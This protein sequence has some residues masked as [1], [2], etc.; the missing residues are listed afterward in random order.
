MLI[1]NK[2]DLEHQRVVSTQE[3][4]DFAKQFDMF[5]VETSVK[6]PQNVNEAF[7]TLAK[8]NCPHFGD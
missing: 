2:A 1:G 3:A 7:I 6:T 4:A 5:Y 8:E